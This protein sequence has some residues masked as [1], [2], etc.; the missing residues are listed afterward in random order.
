MNGIARKVD[1]VLFQVPNARATWSALTQRVGLP[2]AWP[3]FEYR[4]HLSA[5]V[6]FGNAN[7]ELLQPL[8]PTV[9]SGAARILGLA[10]EP[11]SID[12]AVLRLDA[13]RIPHGEPWSF[14]YRIPSGPVVASW[15]NID[16]DPWRSLSIGL[17]VK[18]DRDQD[19]RWRELQSQLASNPAGI[20]GLA[21]V[22]VNAA[23]ETNL[24]DAVLGDQRD[25]PPVPGPLVRLDS[26]DGQMHLVVE[27][28]S[29]PAAVSAFRSAGF[30]I[31]EAREPSVV[32]DQG[33]QSRVVLREA[34]ASTAPGSPQPR[35]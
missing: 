8:E 23:G 28:A 2:F 9:A 10:F 14:E 5:A 11:H 15:T 26:P 13:A 12:D 25:L 17:F 3:P 4:G 24:W 21:E 31:D 22:R 32:F 7:L 29:A 19:E 1:H 30:M 6:S 18:Y 35:G 27:V 33:Q 16:L 34:T 20:R